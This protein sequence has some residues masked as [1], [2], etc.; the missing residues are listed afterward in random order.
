M[1]YL[2]ESLADTPVSPEDPAE[3]RNLLDAAIKGGEP[4]A[5]VILGEFLMKGKLGPKNAPLAE[6]LFAEVSREYPAYGVAVGR[7]Y[8]DE[9]GDAMPKEE[10]TAKGLSYFRRAAE[11]GNAFAARRLGMYF[12]DRH[13]PTPQDLEEGLRWFSMAANKGDVWSMCRVGDIYSKA[14]DPKRRDGNEALLWYGRAAEK[15]YEP[16][17][18]GIAEMYRYGFAV[19]QDLPRAL[20]M[21]RGLAENGL[22]V[23]Q[24]ELG[25]MYE[26]G[27]GVSQSLSHAYFWYV[28]TGEDFDPERERLGKRL[29]QDVRSKMEAEVAA[30]RRTRAEQG[31]H[32]EQARLGEMY[33]KGL[34]VPQSLSQAYFWKVLAGHDWESA[35]ERLAGQ[36]PAAER[37][38]IEAQAAK[39]KPKRTK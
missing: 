25:E 18:F 5:K 14:K 15:G 13:E 2:A 3:A 10:A 9:L 28:L 17:I 38:R 35:R 36:L 4:Y 29:T 11:S 27:L 21:F 31:I 22:S 1:V 34:G 26:M 16:A 32:D 39:W 20:T 6:S 30:W 37:A 12:S 33:E 7:F 23:A 19:P 8:W 24:V